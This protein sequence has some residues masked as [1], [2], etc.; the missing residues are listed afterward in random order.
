MDNCHWRQGPSG[1]R[2]IGFADEAST[3]S[4][5]NARS[6]TIAP[7]L[8]VSKFHSVVCG[9]SSISGLWAIQVEKAGWC[10]SRSELLIPA[11]QHGRV[12]S[13]GLAVSI[14][15]KGLCR[16]Q[17]CGSLTLHIPHVSAN[18]P[19]CLLPSGPVALL[20]ILSTLGPPNFDRFRSF[21]IIDLFVF[22]LEFPCP[23]SV[24]RRIC[25]QFLNSRVRGT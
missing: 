7:T 25:Y 20:P 9:V 18:Y 19:I 23:D 16:V 6:T 10:R 21:V 4:H 1:S 24:R 14:G 12:L 11:L 2:R 8:A 17:L 5:L 3:P 13:E 22:S 15:G